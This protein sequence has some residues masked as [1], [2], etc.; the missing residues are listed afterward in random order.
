V[1]SAG[2]DEAGQF[3]GGGALEQA[4]AIFGGEAVEVVDLG[5]AEHL[6]QVGVDE[7][8]MPD[9]SFGRVLGQFAVN[10]LVGAVAARNPRQLQ[11]LAGVVKQPGYADLRHGAPIG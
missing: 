10:T 6:D 9:Q 2:D 3:P 4:A 8:Q 7:V 11:L 1:A 5:L